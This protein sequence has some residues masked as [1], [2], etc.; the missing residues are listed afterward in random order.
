MLRGTWPHCDFQ[1]NVKI[2]VTRRY[3]LGKA[4]N[5]NYT[6]TI[7]QPSKHPPLWYHH[8]SLGGV[9]LG[10]GV[11]RRS[12]LEPLDLWSVEGV[13]EWDGE[14]LSVLWVDSHG[15]WL[16]NGEL[17]AGEVNL[18]ELVS[19]C[20][21]MVGCVYPSLPCPLGGSSRNPLGSGRSMGAYPASSSWSRGYERRNG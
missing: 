5:K 12:V 7:Q 8:L 11:K 2:H 20:I 14:S 13:C 18:R 16:A 9:G 21:L 15:E 4:I 3:E 10:H 6:S 19:K 17:S 1:E